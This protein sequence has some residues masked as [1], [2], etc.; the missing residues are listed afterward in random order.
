MKMNDLSSA[1][2]PIFETQMEM[3]YNLFLENFKLPS[4]LLR[5]TLDHELENSYV[6]WAPS[7]DNPYEIADYDVKVTYL[8]NGKLSFHYEQFNIEDPDYDDVNMLSQLM[9]G[10]SVGESS[11]DKIWY[12]FFT[13]S[14]SRK[15]NLDI[16]HKAVILNTD[17]LLGMAL[18]LYDLQ[19]QFHDPNNASHILRPNGFQTITENPFGY[20]IF[21]NT[22]GR[23]LQSIYSAYDI[24]VYLVWLIETGKRPGEF[25]TCPMIRSMED[26]MGFE[27]LG[28]P[29]VVFPA[30]FPDFTV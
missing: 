1:I 16:P 22:V 3:L 21:I 19:S 18:A 27:H 9:F 5:I 6:M 7:E 24:G 20:S 29:K 11:L 12:E 10:T 4:E 28:I 30:V 8:T 23:Y 15:W 25:R 26:Q 17:G 13:E 2:K 14:S